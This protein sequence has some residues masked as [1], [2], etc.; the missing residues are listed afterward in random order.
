MSKKTY[1]G[2]LK[3][4]TKEQ[5]YIHPQTNSRQ[6]LTGE[7]NN[8][9][10]QEELNAINDKFAQ[11][12]ENETHKG[13]F[14]DKNELISTFG[15]G[16]SNPQDR[17][18][19]TAIVEDEDKL[20][21]YDTKENK[22]KPTSSGGGT[23]SGIQSVNAKT[24]KNIVLTGSDINSTIDDN[25]TKTITEHLQ[26]IKNISSDGSIVANQTKEK[27]Q[28]LEE[29]IQTLLSNP[30]S[31]FTIN[32]K[33]TYTLFNNNTLKNGIYLLKAGADVY[34]GHEGY[35]G[36]SNYKL[37][38]YSGAILIVQRTNDW[39]SLGGFGS[40]TFQAIDSSE[41]YTGITNHYNSSCNKLPMPQKFTNEGFSTQNFIAKIIDANGTM[42]WIAPDYYTKAQTYTKQQIEELVEN[43]GSSNSSCNCAQELFGTLDN[44][45]VL[46]DL[47]DGDYKI[48]NY[49]KPSNYSSAKTY[50]IIDYN[51]RTAGITDERLFTYVEVSIKK[52][53]DASNN[54][55]YVI[56][57]DYNDIGSYGTTSFGVSQT[58]ERFGGDGIDIVKTGYF[59]IYDTQDTISPI[60]FDQSLFTARYGAS[61]APTN[62]QALDI[63]N[64]IAYTPTND[65]NPATKKY[66]DETVALNSPVKYVENVDEQSPIDNG[67][68]FY[69]VN[70]NS[71][72]Y[73][74]R[75]VETKKIMQVSEE[76]PAKFSS[77]LVV[78]KSILDL[79]L[80]DIVETRDVIA[81]VNI[82]LKTNTGSIA[83]GSNIA[84]RFNVKF[85][86][87]VATEVW[88]STNYG[89]AKIYIYQNGVWNDGLIDLY[90]LSQRELSQ[91]TYPY[92][93]LYTTATETSAEYYIKDKLTI[94]TLE[95]KKDALAFKEENGS[96]NLDETN[97]VADINLSLDTSN[98]VL[99]AQLVNKDGTTIGSAKTIDLPLESVVVNAS[100]NNSTKEITLTLNNGSTTS[101][102][103]A[104][105]VS[106]LVSSTTKINGKS[107]D[108][109]IELTGDDITAI[110]GEFGS[111]A[112]YFKNIQTNIIDKFDA[113]NIPFNKEDEASVTIGEAFVNLMG[114][115][116]ET[117]S[118]AFGK[119]VY[120]T[121][122]GIDGD[123]NDITFRIPAVVGLLQ[124]YYYDNP[125]YSGEIKVRIIGMGENNATIT[126]ISA[127]SGVEIHT[128][129]RYVKLQDL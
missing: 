102:S 92:F 8:S 118:S 99:T 24:D 85:Q 128:T 36:S 35:S 107:L 124:T 52:E 66:V 120:V 116:E 38:L 97:F 106:G 43:V 54:R 53:A 81:T 63:Y 90:K 56:L 123:E 109:N 108:S 103:V 5:N 69:S 93:Y 79:V 4:N 59:A 16:I 20:Y 13:A 41:I 10:L 122:T 86:N 62:Y 98:Y 78:D 7:N 68:Y 37:K 100:Y 119:I 121:V 3:D 61:N 88:F 115:L 14:A 55:K 65:Y 17:A 73:L 30:N 75:G 48:Y 25:N 96:S 49:V 11:L 18:G 64:S 126:A 129:G 40:T 94:T 80:P 82:N 95:T 110:N 26:D 104:D 83:S 111:I 91:T 6:V 101:F 74:I 60:T 76:I 77:S 50:A 15:E 51:T 44:P 47:E 113:M 70:S 34:Y 9:N 125:Y 31:V 2:I 42:Q 46:I 23:G 33:A 45:I 19:W 27:T 22:W 29:Q 57:K 117:L 87:G 105:L 112:T 114:Q 32:E 21:F 84:P 72:V 89:A 39:G 127:P 58:I 67:A 1:N 71:D 12:Q 28:Y